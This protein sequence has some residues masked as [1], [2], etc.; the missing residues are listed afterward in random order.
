MSYLKVNQPRIKFDTS[1]APPHFTIKD[2]SR[3]SNYVFKIFYED[4]EVGA[5]DSFGCYPVSKEEVIEFATKYDPQPFH[6]NEEAAKQSVFGGLC[7][8]GWHTCAMLM[9]MTV[10][11]MMAKGTAGLGSPGIDG[12][13]WK[14]PVMVGDTL[15]VKAKTTDKR[16]SKSRPNIGLVKSTS[17][18]F[19]QSGDLVMA[20]HTN[21]MIAKR[22][23]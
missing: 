3:G 13:E 2:R 22:K 7:A 20:V 5:E 15:S 6:L 4:I 19:N 21:Y 10:D 17:E 18:V 16:E 9:R 12:I 1:S 14:K 23:T 8:S 11:H